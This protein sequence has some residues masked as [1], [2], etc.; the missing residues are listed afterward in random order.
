MTRT[1]IIITLLLPAALLSYNLTGDDFML[2]N[3][4]TADSAAFDFYTGQINPS[5]AESSEFTPFPSHPDYPGKPQIISR[6]W[7]DSGSFELSLEATEPTNYYL[8]PSCRYDAIANNLHLSLWVF[9][10]ATG[11]AIDIG[12]GTYNLP[13]TGISGDLSY[14][15]K[16]WTADIDLTGSG[17]SFGEY[18]AVFT[19]A[20]AQVSKPFKIV[21]NSGIITGTI[22]DLAENP[23]NGANVRLFHSY[24]YSPLGIN[25][26]TDTTTDPDGFYQFGPL[27]RGW[28]TLDVQAA[29]Y[30]RQHKTFF[31]A[32]Q[33]YGD[34]DVI[35]PVSGSL[36]EL[37]PA[38]R[39][40]RNS[41]DDALEHGCEVMSRITGEAKGDLR[42]SFDAWDIVS[43]IGGATSSLANSAIKGTMKTA[44]KE[45]VLKETFNTLINADIELSISLATQAFLPADKD[46]WKQFTVSEL[47]Q[48]GVYTDSQ[49]FLHDA[50]ADFENNDSQVVPAS[51]FDFSS[52]ANMI[53]SQKKQLKRFSEG[54]PISVVALP[55]YGDINESCYQLGLPG[56]EQA[57]KKNHA[58][59]VAIG[60]LSKT[61]AVLQI[62]SGATAG[63]LTVTG[64]G[65]PVAA[66]AA[67]ICKGATAVKEIS[68]YATIGLQTVGGFIYVDNIKNWP[69]DTAMLPLSFTASA[70]ILSDEAAS[71][72]YLS[73]WNSFSGQLEL[74]INSS[75]NNILVPPLFPKSVFNHATVGITNTSNVPADFRVITHGW[76]DYRLPSG[77]LHFLDNI[78]GGVREIKIPTT[79]TPPVDMGNIDVGLSSS[80]DII[81]MGYYIDPVNMFSPHWLKI[82]AYAGPHLVDSITKYYFV[83]LTGDQIVKAK[84]D[85]SDFNSAIA[86]SYKSKD[87]EKTLD[88]GG[89]ETMMPAVTSLVQ[90]ELSSGNIVCSYQHTAGPD[91]WSVSYKLVA[92]KDAKIA[93]RVYDANGYC[94]GYDSSRG[95]ELAEFVGEYTGTG[96]G[97]QSVD[98]VQAAGQTYIV[99]AVLEGMDQPGTFDVELYAFE[100][101][102]RPAI[103]SV[104]TQSI[105]QSAQWN[106]VLELN[107]LVG[108]GG[109]QQPVLN[110]TAH[111]SDLVRQDGSEVIPSV[112]KYATIGNI[113]AGSADTVSFEMRVPR[114]AVVGDYTGTIMISSDNA[115]SVEIPV[116]ITVDDNPADFTRDGSVDYSD[117]YY[118]ASKWLKTD[119]IEPSWCGGTDLN[120]DTIVDLFDYSA[121]SVNWLWSAGTSVLDPGEILINSELIVLGDGGGEG[122]GTP[123]GTN[124]QDSFEISQIP[125]S[126]P[127]LSIEYAGADY[128]N[129]VY[130]NDVQVG[131]L[132]DDIEGTDWL[133]LD[134]TVGSEILVTGANTIKIQ[135]GNVGINYDDFAV[136]QILLEY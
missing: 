27:A 29:G 104:M 90:S 119:C 77:Y 62:A 69:L 78:F 42:S 28:Y 1:I 59:Y 23:I 82:D 91:V 102:I 36:A 17:L 74:N 54:E 55:G 39:S 136:R 57:W 41:V 40:L 94:V 100:T 92:S 122:L 103:L 58:A 106:N 45:I 109:H 88:E 50:Y 10:K 112:T 118:L 6:E 89:Y 64:V 34:L 60:S 9:D 135:A 116:T 51:N 61:A 101:P 128:D 84:S 125:D 120:T 81:F 49:Q 132:D 32:G 68:G 66:G 126:D 7:A 35:L 129:R 2:G 70:D 131:I 46:D 133:T 114:D 53:N 43:Y 52:A 3:L 105:A 108:E 111:L 97:M 15:G 115:G 123:T 5:T 11:V 117:L 98:I 110:V 16:F 87:I 21:S 72:W 134:F 71:P 38:M 4:T 124:W 83:A 47:K 8:M 48:F 14:D 65:A 30:T 26:I 13:D 86:A 56:S 33:V 75:E 80:Q 85:G 44:L 95:G 24:Y 79:V 130:I 107:T 12:G 31:V 25:Y 18:D 127:T 96:S 19:F 121:F 22:K 67:V 76:W 93:L 20:D 113:S 99:E 37:I 63:V 73:S